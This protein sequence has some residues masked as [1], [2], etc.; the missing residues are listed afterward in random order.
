MF[1]RKVHK[2]WLED[3]LCEEDIPH[4]LFHQVSVFTEEAN[5]FLHNK[6]VHMKEN[7]SGEI[8]K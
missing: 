5:Y 1:A 4:T 3:K 8:N 2:A 6:L 7:C